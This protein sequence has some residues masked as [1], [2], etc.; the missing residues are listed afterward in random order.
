M[1]RVIFTSNHSED[2]DE[3]PPTGQK[4]LGMLINFWGFANHRIN[5]L[6]SIE[7]RLKQGDEIVASFLDSP[8]LNGT[9]VIYK[10]NGSVNSFD[11]VIPEVIPY[12]ELMQALDRVDGFIL[13]GNSIPQPHQ[14]PAQPTSPYH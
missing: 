11:L 8:R 14:L 7:D 6:K 9:S 10:P 3:P 12:Q 5:G 1:R 4:P 2:S 13:N